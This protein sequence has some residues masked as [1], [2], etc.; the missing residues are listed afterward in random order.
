ML[1]IAGG[2]AIGLLSLGALTYY[3]Y[4]RIRDTDPGMPNPAQGHNFSTTPLRFPFQ[5]ATIHIHR[6]TDSPEHPVM[7]V[8]I[9]L[10]EG[11]GLLKARLANTAAIMKAFDLPDDTKAVQIGLAAPV[12]TRIRPLYPIG[13]DRVLVWNHSDLGTWQSLYTRQRLQELYRR[14]APGGILIY[15]PEN[16]SQ[17]DQ[18]IREALETL[19]LGF[20]DIHA[21]HPE[22]PNLPEAPAAVFIKEGTPTWGTSLSRNHRLEIIPPLLF[23]AGIA[24]Y[25]L[26]AADFLMSHAGVSMFMSV[27]AIAIAHPGVSPKPLYSRRPEEF[28]EARRKVMEFLEPLPR[29]VVAFGSARIPQGDPSYTLAYNF[30]RALFKYRLPPRTGAGPSIMEAVLKGYRDAYYFLPGTKQTM[31]RLFDLL[32]L[33]QMFKMERRPIY[34]VGESFW[35]Q[36]LGPSLR[37]MLTPIPVLDEMT[38]LPAMNPLTGLPKTYSLITPGDENLLRLTNGLSDRHPPIKHTPVLLNR[39]A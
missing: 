21:F 30:G 12:A 24:G 14:L 19:H 22:T 9:Y 26:G 39:A 2:F 18:T 11:Q 23:F 1:G 6:T 32:Q 33:I 20:N 5:H 8:W 3:R 27:A 17:M 34:L 16:T 15:F 28:T 37:L 36:F 13:Q 35:K 10:R 31:N 25:A 29:A 38:G 7:K 4:L